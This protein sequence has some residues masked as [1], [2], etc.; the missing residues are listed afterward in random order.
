MRR[1]SGNVVIHELGRD[2]AV[3][4]TTSR[5]VWTAGGQVPRLS[6]ADGEHLDPWQPARS[7]G[8]ELRIAIRT[9]GPDAVEGGLELGIRGAGPERP[10]EGRAVW[11]EQGCVERSP[12]RQ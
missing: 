10:A 2:P 3:V 9:R 5:H 1:R 8:P 4:S 7:V 11:A 12:F 6:A